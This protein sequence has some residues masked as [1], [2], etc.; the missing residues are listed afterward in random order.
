MEKEKKKHMKKI[1]IKKVLKISLKV[2]LIL[3]VFILCSTIAINMQYNH[4]PDEAMKYDVCRFIYTYRALPHGG[5]ELIREVNWGISYAF[6]PILSYMFSAVFMIITSWFTNDDG[7]IFIASRFVSVFCMSAYVFINIQ[8]SKKLFKGIFRGLYLVFVTLIPQMIFLGSYLNNDAF[9]MFTV[10]IIVYSWLLGI[11]KNWD[12]KSCIFLAIGIGLCAL[13]YYNAYGYILFSVIIYFV[14]NF[15]KKTDIKEFLKKGIVIA[16]VACAIGGWWFVRSYILYDG[17]IFGLNVSREYGEKY[18]VDWLKPSN[19]GTPNKLHTPL[20]EM[21]TTNGW[22]RMTRT[23]FIG[24][25]GN[26]DVWMHKY[27]YRGY[28][29]IFIAGFIGLLLSYIFG[30]VCLIK[31]NKKAGKDIKKKDNKTEDLKII[32]EEANIENEKIEESITEIEKV[33]NEIEENAKKNKLKRKEKIMLDIIMFINI[34]I[35]I[36]L[37]MYYSYFNDFQPQGRYIMPIIIPFMYFIVQG[38]EFIFKKTIRNKIA[39]NI[40]VSIIII[41]WSLMPI[42]ALIKCIKPRLF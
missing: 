36:C 20:K 7:I 2:I 29:T 10:A 31:S 9:A 6:T 33:D 26:F 38:L 23:S 14:S 37:S 5:D 30:I 28:N 27:V 15:I 1:D 18:A 12:W 16:A 22:I 13:S 19:R 11:E 34:I 8:I 32:K 42:Y 21:L 25:F 17:D 3:Y 41:V 40:M 24:G 35:P 39:I 4:A